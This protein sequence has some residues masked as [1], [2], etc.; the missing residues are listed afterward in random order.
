MKPFG[1]F[2]GVIA[3]LLYASSAAIG[4]NMRPED[5]VPDAAVE[6]LISGRSGGGRSYG[7]TRG[8]RAHKRW[9]TA[10]ASGRHDFRRTLARG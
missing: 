5:P 8:G 1:G 10:R 4:I 9:K 7:T 6:A 3:G 2:F